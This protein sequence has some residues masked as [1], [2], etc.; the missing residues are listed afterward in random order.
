MSG[1]YMGKIL[2]LDLTGKKVSTLDTS[3]YEEYGGG[4]G[5]GTAIF[6]DLCADKLP[7]DAYDPQ[8]IVTIMTSPLSG[9]LTPGAGRCEM[10]GLGPQSY[11]IH[12]FTRSNFGGRFAGH[13]KAAGWDGIVIEGKSDKPIW[14]N[15][16]NDKVTFMDASG[17]WGKD[18]FATQQQIWDLVTGGL[19]AEGW[20]QFGSSMDA[21]RTTQKPAVLCIGPLG[22]VRAG[23]LGA[24]IHDA[25]CACGQGGFGAVWGSKNLK[26]IS[27]IGTGGILVADPRALLEAWQWLTARR[28]GY[29]QPIGD[30]IGSVGTYGPVADGITSGPVACMGCPKACHG[31]RNAYGTQSEVFCANRG[32]VGEI[33]NKMG[34]NTFPMMRFVPYLGTLYN[35]G[36]LGPGKTINS[37]L[38]FDLLAT[39]EPE[40]VQ[41]LLDSIVKGEDIGLDLRDGIIRA[42]IKWGREKD[43]KTGLLSFPYWGWPEHC[44]DPRAEVEWG[45]GSILGDRDINEHMIAWRFYLTFAHAGANP[46]TNISAE[47]AATIFSEKL[48]PYEGDPLVLDYSTDNIYSEHMVKLVAW[49]R[50]YTSFYQEGLLFCDFMWPDTVN[51]YAPNNRGYTVEGEPKFF[52]AVTGK[53]LNFAEGMEIGRKIW[54]LRNAIWTLQGRHRDMV[55]CADYIYDSPTAGWWAFGPVYLLP[56]YIDGKW[57]YTD[58]AGRAIDRT[59]FDEFKTKFYVLEGWD[60]ESGW[61]TRKTLEGL[62]L[63]NVADTLEAKGKLGRP[64]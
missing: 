63:K 32:P 9:T 4:L 12:W 1:G 22:E 34:A 46:P 2:R 42:C 43:W 55:Y 54:N 19:Q 10:N 6:W 11:P 13:L 48:I 58:V 14:V 37:D 24:L 56:T 62:N 7:F 35:Q 18:T 50:H 38:P 36:I 5:F 29:K 21:G 59:K 45:Y 15:I 49:H 30:K 44:Y 53:K 51:P 64:G 17:L 8:N 27:V 41:L 16:V 33:Q 28:P 23:E 26:A 40:V 47:E 39:K 31:V 60:T 57:A 20:Y 61:P 52:N 25:G 3:R